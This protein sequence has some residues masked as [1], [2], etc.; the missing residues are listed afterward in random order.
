MF[1]TLDVYLARARGFDTDTAG[2]AAPQA[3]P[4]VAP[5]LTGGGQAGASIVVVDTSVDDY[6]TLIADI[7]PGTEIVYVDGATGGLADV[8]AALEGHADIAAL[9]IV[10]HG[11]TGLIR[12][13]QDT[14][15]DATLDAHA[16]ALDD[17][18]AALGDGADILLYGCN[19]G[20][21]GAGRGFIDTLAAM[22]GA[23]IAAST[24]LTGAAAHGG[25]WDL[26]IATGTIEV[27]QPF[28]AKALADFSEVLST[29]IF[30][31]NGVTTG[32]ANGAA[33]NDATFTQHGYT[34]TLDGATISTYIQNGYAYTSLGE[35][36]LTIDFGPGIQ[37]TPTELYIFDAANGIEID[38][39]TNVGGQLVEANLGA[40]ASSTVDLTPLEDNVTSLILT[41]S[42]PMGGSNSNILIGDL[43]VSNIGAANAAPTIALDNSTLAYSENAAAVQIDSA[44]T[45]NDTDG[46]ADWNTGTLVA[47]VTG[48]AESADRI[49]ISDTDGDGTA[50][51][52]SGTNILANGTDVGDLSVSGGTVTGGTALTITFD[53]DA[54]N[55]IVQEVMQSLRYDNTSDAPGTLDRTVTITATDANSGN[56]SD[57]RTISVTAVN[58]APV[59]T[60]GG[61]LGAVDEDTS[62]PAGAA[63]NSLGI[64]ATDADSGSSVSGYAIVDNA[65]SSGAE[66][67]WQYSTDSGSNWFDIAAVADD[68]TALALSATT[69][70]RFVPVAD[71]NGTPLGLGV[72]ALDD[73]YGG[74]FTSGASRTTVDTTTNGAAT[75]ISG[76]TQ[77]IA[78]SVT[79]VNDAPVFTGLNG[80]PGYTEDSTPV[81]LDADVTIADTELDIGNVGNGDYAGASLTIA[82]NGGANAADDF[83]FDTAGASFTVSGGNL[84]AGGQTFAT[85]TD[86]SGTLTINFTSSPATATSALV[87]EVMQRITY[88]NSNDNPPANVQLDWAFSDGNSA[89]AQGTGDNPGIGTGSVTV[90]ITGVNDA[91]VLNT[92]ASPTLT[93]ILEDAGAPVNGSTAGSTLVSSLVDSGGALNN[94][95][96]GDGDAP[97]IAVTGVSAQGTLFYSTDGGT[98]WTELTGAVSNTSALLLNADANTRLY[99]QPD[100]NT[101]FTS[102]TDAVTF[103]AW[104]RTSGV[105]GA[106]GAN[107]TSGTAFSSASDTAAVS[108]TAVN[109]APVFTGLDGTP[110]Y[111]EDGT[112]VVLDADVTIADVEL[113]ALN[114]GNGDYA[115][116]SLTIARNGG[117]NADDDFG[118]DTAG[119][120]FSVSGNDLVA[121][122]FTFATFTETAGTLTI[123]FTSSIITATTPQVDEVMQRITYQNTSDAPPA[124]VQLDWSFSDGNSGNAQGTGDNPGTDSGSVTVSITG[125]NDAPALDNTQSPTLTGISEDAGDDDGSGADGDDD[126]TNNAN[127]GGTSIATLVVDGSITDADGSA[128]EAI[129]VVAV[130]NTNGVWQYSTDNGTNWVDFSGT[131]G[132]T[133][134]L[135]S[136]SRLLDGTLTGANTQ[137]VRFVPDADYTGTAEI[138]FRAWDR[139]S[140]SAG[141]TADTTTTGTTTP[142]SSASDT[143]AVT[144]SAVNDAPVIADLDG[145][146][147][148]YTEDAGALTLDQGTGAGVTDVDNPT[149]F[150]G[151]NLTVSVGSATS[152]EDLSIP[153]QGTGAGQIGVSGTT[154]SYEGNAIGTITSDGQNGTDLVV[155][156]NTANATPAAVQA[157]ARAVTYANDNQ[158]P[159]GSRT[160][161]FTVNDGDG[162]TSTSAAADV[163]VN[164][165]ATNDAPALDNTQSPTL[166]GI[167]EDAG[168]DNGS[169]ADGDDDA[170]NNA[171]NGGTNIATLVVDGSITDADGSAVEAIAVVA[172]DN[173]NGVWQYSTDNGT[174][175]VDFSGTTGSTVDLTSASRLLDGT[176]TGA[177]T[178]L[179]RFVPDAD[180]T[181]TAEITFRAWDR[182]SGSAGGTADT[183]TTGTTTPFSSA[184]DTAAVTVSA[185]NDAPVFTGLDGTPGYTE[186][187]TAVVLD[188]DVTI[189][190]VELDALNSGN[191]NYTG[192]SLTIARNGGANADDQFSVASGGAISVSG[193]DISTGG[194][195]IATI[196]TT[197]TPGQIVIT[198]QTAGLSPDSAVVDD[199]LQA[200]R[201]ANGSDDPPAS[202]QLDWSFSDGNSGDAQGTGDNPGI[203][204][205]SVTVSITGVNDEPTLTAIG[206]T[207]TFE[208]GGSAADLFSAVTASTVESGQTFAGMTLTVTNVS[209]GADEV[210]TIDGTAVALTN[211]GAGTTATNGLTYGV[212]VTSGTATVTLSGGTMSP[213]A[214][215]TLVDGLT[216]ENGS[217]DPSTGANRVV[218]ITQLVDSGSST[219]AN[220]NSAVL[221]LS[222]TVSLTAVNDAP[223]VGGVFG[224]TTSQVVAG[225]G[226][227]N[228]TGLDDATVANADSADYNGG[229]LTIAQ[230]TGTANG[231]WG[232]DG[233]GVTSTPSGG[234]T[235]GATIAAGNTI[236]VGGV[237]IGT[238]DATGNGQGGSTLTINFTTADATSANIQALLRNLTYDGPSGIDTRQFTL[239][240]NDNDGTAGTGG[241][242]DASGS[243]SI[244]VTPNPPVLANL[245]GDSFTFTDGDSA[246]AID[247][248]GNVTV[249]DPDSTDF[250]GGVLTVAYQS[251]QAAD[252]RL[253][254]DTSGTVV[255]SAGQ[256][257]GSTVSVGGTAIGTLQSG[258]TGGAS[259]DLVIALNADATPARV[260]TLL[261]DIQYDNAGGNTPTDGARVLRVTLSDGD[262][263][264]S[265]NADITVTVNAVNEAPTLTAT[266]A[267]PAYTEGDTGDSAADLFSSVTADTV[268]TGETITGLTLTVTGL[269]DGADERLAFDGSTLQLTDGFNVASTAT[270]GLNVSVAVSGTTATVSFSGATLSEAQVQMLVDDLAYEN[271]GQDP[272]AGNRVVTV[273]QITDSGGTA[274][275]GDDTGAPNI[276]STVSVT[277]VDDEPTLSA[278]GS[279]PAFVEDG[280][281]A[282]L[283]SGVTVSTVESGQTVTGLTLTVTNVADGMNE[284]L[285][286][287]GGSFALVDGNSGTTTTNGLG[288]SVSVS[289]GTA[290]V[291]LSGGSLTEAQ[292]QGMIDGLTYENASDEPTT[293]GSRVVTITGI[294]DSGANTGVNDNAATVNLASTVSVTEANDAPTLTA[295]GLTPQFLFGGSAVDLFDTVTASTV[296]SGQSLT[297]LT[298]TVTDV[299]NGASETLTIDGT[300]VSLADGTSGTTATNSLSY[301]VSTTG[302]T[303][304]VTLSGGSL[305]ATDM[306]TLVDGLTYENS[307][308][309]AGTRNVTITSLGDDGG[310][311]NGGSDTASLSL[312]ATVNLGDPPPPPPNTPPTTGGGSAGLD[313]GAA[314]SLRTGDFGFNDADGDPLR[315]VIIDSLPEIGTLTLN[316]V[317]VSVGQSIR[318]SEISAGRLVYTSDVR[319]ADARFTFRVSDG[320]DT[321]G[322]ARFDLLVADPEPVDPGDPGD[323]GNGGGEP[324]DDLEGTPAADTLIGGDEDDVVRGQEGDDNIRGAGGDDEILAGRRDN[325]N[326]TLSGGTGNDTLG[327]GV[328][329]D[330]IDGGDDDDILFGREGRDTLLGGD[331]NDIIF[332]GDGDDTVNGGF[333][334][335][336]LWGSDGD[337]LLIGG[338]GSDTFTFGV[339]AG[340]D[341]VADF[342]LGDDALDLRYAVRDFESL[343]DVAAAARLSVDGNGNPSLVIDLGPGEDGTPQSVSLTGLTLADLNNM[344]ILI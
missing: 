59:L 5:V 26:E 16:D 75:A 329:D 83:G 11:N 305:T 168:N 202:V 105:N 244:S 39:T 76:N 326:D 277:A 174:N 165:T 192:A 68:A 217:D 149:D 72:R 182:S 9:H 215:Q 180:Y 171:N 103:K 211:G 322:A 33:G 77:T 258:G 262:G 173:T 35:T 21:D 327:G 308:S 113:D 177:N 330:S 263:A 190:D 272:T 179:V 86:T 245:G 315:T 264:T 299:A 249:T 143:A 138:T 107:T 282:D 167:A 144:V 289:S 206:A 150:N 269:A 276:A 240:L 43:T 148:A 130:D 216:Y 116:A 226:P 99:F 199:V 111:T 133:V 49:S 69:L 301:A 115:G 225:T 336:T 160:V 185:V 151:G 309:T 29:T 312:V 40:F 205:G 214:L 317:A 196:D 52:I 285:G 60:G 239:T 57:T 18:A 319:G 255:L 96:D 241:D 172:V 110:G 67:V 166:S 271:A 338:A 25:D 20:A 227:G 207:P 147:L 38:I 126:A 106:T 34:L 65:A 332:T 197:T 124:S 178:Q 191:G 87:D 109:D 81:V 247:V 223:D 54:T 342:D 228:L 80:T 120:G 22:T 170:T 189:A 114:T 61:T 294:T 139:S 91:P 316:G 155:T 44:G 187:G 6:E 314:Y 146:I 140:G 145:D 156:F 181:G 14:L 260:Q 119:A 159:S 193:T 123:N 64:T 121:G 157:L 71:Y 281:P 333:G 37:F 295:T 235:P 302:G 56:N 101:N 141:G 280:G 254:I 257:A 222:S 23:D 36:V 293:A 339:L 288:Y 164:L 320:E 234:G 203:G 28:S 188:A 90:S 200:I 10:S 32:S 267:D 2:Q 340:N 132:S 153:N 142:F 41:F 31:F 117:A 237:V 158:A 231:N 70:V 303:A 344:T 154:V 66:G 218:T 97:G 186:G 112:A 98:N 250:G 122:G 161:S 341:R 89:N 17:I 8:A 136:A 246:T 47:Q 184:S 311:A 212:S 261:R 82:R 286:V 84:Q 204:T 208:E 252:D 152:N 94:F 163:T 283:F 248:D 328:G 100:A 221:N 78:T 292:A 324:G 209:D 176:L 287:D 213:A 236:E 198:F 313:A 296:E 284:L 42:V 232:V 233:T 230:T 278:T 298:L 4:D 265:A 274:N 195:V 243:F 79:A 55:A 183:T 279:D 88:Q 129:A 268:E 125:V 300:A 51:T 323:P 3:V 175:W 273:T 251:G 343:D 134:D 104:D 108:V 219:G 220:D 135:T 128:V 210:L 304:T 58:D 73:S 238:V 137:L 118:F 259:E 46:D 53:T 92:A 127:N 337:D 256:T 291:T 93:T 30:D 318:A 310:T 335:D 275:N 169:G 74:G 63:L 24:D 50:I 321:S 48:N 331:G 325:G 270:N 201:Y 224:D 19:V 307:S 229:F 297:G 27:D 242:E 45:V 306:Q 13:G 266:G 85:F 95:S 131:T 62:A 7:A 1:D 290:T 15:S 253:V 162:G 194:N 334:N 12:L 102:L